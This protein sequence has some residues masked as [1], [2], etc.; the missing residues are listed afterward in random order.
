M[1]ASRRV[2]QALHA[3][4]LGE[5]GRGRRTCLARIHES[6]YETRH[7]RYPRIGWMILIRI[8]DRDR[9]QRAIA[10]ASVHQLEAA[11]IVGSWICQDERAVVTVELDAVPGAE[12]GRAA[13]LQA[14]PGARC[15]GQR[16]RNAALGVAIEQGKH[17][18][19]Q[20]GDRAAK[21]FEIVEAMADEVAEQA[22][23]AIAARLPAVEPHTY[24]PVLDVP[25]HNRVA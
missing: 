11:E 2:D 23:A 12:Q 15:E 4:T 10:A 25:G 21:P 19:A 9:L 24:G 18:A 3:I 8:L 7:R 13:H 6:T 5:S 1:R 14:A 17:A 22:A 16:Q 20:A